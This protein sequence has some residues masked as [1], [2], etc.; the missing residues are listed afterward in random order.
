M[1][2]RSRSVHRHRD[3]RRDSRVVLCPLERAKRLEDVLEEKEDLPFSSRHCCCFFSISRVFVGSFEA[4]SCA[5]SGCLPE[6]GSGGLLFDGNAD[7][8]DGE[9]RDG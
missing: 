1:G 8:S 9:K 2:A 3:D 7:R 4:L 6:G 5:T